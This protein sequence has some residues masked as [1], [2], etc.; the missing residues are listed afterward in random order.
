V[1][2]RDLSTGRGG[3]FVNPGFTTDVADDPIVT[4]N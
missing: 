1:V 4:V 2:R 3:L